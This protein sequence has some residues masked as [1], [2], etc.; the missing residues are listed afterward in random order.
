M[1]VLTKK[2]KDVSVCVRA[3]PSVHGGDRT[4]LSLSL[5]E[6]SGQASG[7]LA[8][9]NAEPLGRLQCVE[10]RPSLLGLKT[11]TITNPYLQFKFS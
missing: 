6:A 7:G 10:R 2:Y 3:C 4:Q 5:D 9:M 11:K 1:K 8:E